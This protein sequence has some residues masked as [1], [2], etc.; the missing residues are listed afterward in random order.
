MPPKYSNYREP[1]SKDNDDN[2]PYESEISWAKSSNNSQA[3][4][5]YRPK[6]E[7]PLSE[8]EEE[9]LARAEDLEYFQG[10]E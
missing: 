3:S 1:T 2:T 5:D 8:E 7:E 4:H 6:E 9:V 10:P